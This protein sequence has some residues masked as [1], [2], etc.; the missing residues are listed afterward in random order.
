MNDTVL[1]IENV[2]KEY[3]LGVISHKTLTRDLQSWWARQRGKEDPNLPVSMQ[4][5]RI[6]SDNR[7]WALKD[8]SF[9]VKQGEI[10]G[11]VG[12]NGAGKSTLLKILSRVTTP[13]KGQIKVKGH[14][15]SLLEVGTGF[16]PELTGRENI[17]LNGAIHGMNKVDIRKKLDEIISFAEIEQFIHTPVKRYSSGMY[18]RLAFAVAAHLE[19]EL[20][21][22]DEVLAV[23]DA[24]FQKKCLGKMGDVAKKGRTVLFVSHNMAAVQQLCQRGL[25]LTNGAVELDNDIETVISYY[26]KRTEET[27]AR[28]EWLEQENVPLGNYY[29]SLK[30]MAVTDEYGSA[31][32]MPLRNDVDFYFTV[33]FDLKHEDRSFQIGLAVYD[34]DNRLLFWSFNTDTD[35]NNW[36]KTAVGRNVLR[37][38]FPKNLLNE[39]TYRLALLAACYHRE[40]L[41]KPDE[42][43]ACLFFEIRGGLSQSPY[44]YEKRRGILAPVLSWQ[45]GAEE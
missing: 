1:K 11:I 4:N 12:R 17:F 32:T 15:A 43:T 18:V 6:P 37:V 44:W 26:S 29:F 33:E 20:L 21:V 2:S 38:R 10:L 14:V 31:L 34:S 23:G 45:A 40:W 8:V 27:H 30:R 7:F 9:E 13:T 39:G 19:P 28:N 42:D 3:R 22:V 16:H 5:Q 36:P 41:L 35:E 24:S 25:L